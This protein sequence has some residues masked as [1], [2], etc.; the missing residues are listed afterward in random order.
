MNAFL[1][2]W[3]L[4]APPTPAELITSELGVPPLAEF[5][6]TLHKAY[7]PDEITI[8]MVKKSPQMY[9]VR[10]AVND[11]SFVMYD[12]YKLKLKQELFE[13]RMDANK[14]ELLEIQEDLAEVILKLREAH[15]DLAKVAAKRKSEHSRRWE[16]HL[17]Y[18][19]AATRL[20]AASLEELNLAYGTVHKN[21]LPKL[22]EKLMQTGWKIE[23]TAKMHSKADIRKLDEEARADMAT[24]KETYPGTPWAKLAERDLKTE[25]GLKWV[26]SVVKPPPPL[27]VDPKKKKPN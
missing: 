19:L 13:G 24:L 4:T 27:K 10:A 17:D 11:V 20:R 18:L 21:E 25:P 8:E 26:G 15:D 1:L 23:P 22:D 5:T 6:E 14:K 7:Q 9:P 12:A 16:A 3:V 2:C